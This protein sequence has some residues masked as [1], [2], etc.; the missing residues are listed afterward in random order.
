MTIAEAKQELVYLAR[1]QVGYQ[2][3]PNN[4]TKYAEDPKIIQLYGWCPQN[5]PWCCTFVN[6]TF[7]NA[8]GYDIGSQLTYGGTAACSS[9]AQLFRNHGAFVTTPEVGNQA[10]FYSGGGI[11]HTG[12]VVDVQGSIF[13]TIEGNYS[14][15]VSVVHHNLTGS[16]V[17]GFGRPCWGIVEG[18]SD[19]PDDPVQPDTPVQPSRILRKYVSGED[20]R[21]L[22]EELIELGYD[23]GPDGADGKFGDNTEK[24]VMQFQRDHGLDAD[25]QVGPLTYAALEEALSEEDTEQK[26]PEDEPEDKPPEEQENQG[27]NLILPELQVGDKGNA[28]A[29]LQAALNLREFDC[30]K[31]DG[32]FGPKT[33]AALNRFKE[34]CGL[35]QNGKTDKKTWELLLRLG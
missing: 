8:F 23:V 12:I 34:A 28:V 29:L 5:Q 17:A 1:S 9:S 15:K 2:E 27:C 11:N 3:G 18:S 7:L 26:P 4:Y 25:G 19:V 22:Q 33:A 16:E 6:W 13:T 21:Q 35:E 30:G 32:D 31:A 20:V 14:D 24:A 10:F